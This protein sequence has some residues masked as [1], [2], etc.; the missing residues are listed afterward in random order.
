MKKVLIVETN[1]LSPG[2]LGRAI[3][4]LGYQPLFLVHPGEHAGDVLGELASFPV[5]WVDE[6]LDDEYLLRFL[7]QDDAIAGIV[8]LADL[9]VAAA[10]RA[11]RRAG[12]PG[13]APEIAQMNNKA[14][15]QQT[16][17]EYCPPGRPFHTP[18]TAAERGALHALLAGA[19]RLRIKPAWGTG[20]AGQCVVASDAGLDNFLERAPAR[21]WV[22]QAFLPGSRYGLYSLEGFVH[23]GRLHDLGISRWRRFGLTQT[24]NLFPV[25]ADERITPAVRERMRH[26]LRTA[27]A[28]LPLAPAALNFWFHAEFLVGSGEVYWIDPNLGRFGGA[29]IPWHLALSMGVDPTLLAR[30]FVSLT[31]GLGPLPDLPEPMVETESIGYVLDTPA[32]I[33]A[34]DDSACRLPFHRLL[35]DP[36]MTVGAYAE[37]TWDFIGVA[38]GR[39]DQDIPAEVDKIRILTSDGRVLRP[40]Y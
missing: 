23:Q 4:E 29:E 27:C 13:L 2:L 28:R 5:H 10:A 17:A 19:G 15:L 11:A 39:A 21:R 37:D 20:G 35:I 9:F 7:A 36:G 8:T 38:L 18:T 6:R 33:A 16:M 25:W 24:G 1:D 40:C 32:T 22:A 12:L 26:T 30:H 34:V 14:D 3:L 31:L